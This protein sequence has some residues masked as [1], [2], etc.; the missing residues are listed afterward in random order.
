MTEVKL[1]VILRVLLWKQVR[2]GAR[3]AD[4]P[5]TWAVDEVEQQMKDCERW[6]MSEFS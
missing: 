5:K 3:L 4:F 6:N 1:H 2:G